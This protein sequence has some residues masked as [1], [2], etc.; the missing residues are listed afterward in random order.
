V[1]WVHYPVVLFALFVDRGKERR[2]KEKKGKGRKG[3]G[4]E[5]GD[6]FVV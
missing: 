3:K 2:G 4:R 5:V 6:C 1:L